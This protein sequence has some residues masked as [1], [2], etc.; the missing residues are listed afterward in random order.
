[1]S[2]LA[3]AF[4]QRHD[5]PGHWLDVQSLAAAP[6]WSPERTAALAGQCR[7]ALL[8]D[9]AQNF[10]D[11]WGPR[12]S[13]VI[14]DGLAELSPLLPEAPRAT[15]WYPV[16]LQLRVTE[17]LLDEV[18][19]GDVQGLRDALK[20]LVT[21]HR[22]A[23]FVARRMGLKRLVQK[24]GGLFGQCYD[25][26]QTEVR[27]S[28]GHAVITVAGAEL[29]THPTWQLL[30]LVGY[31]VLAELAGERDAEVYGRVGPGRVFEAHLEW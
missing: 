12:T 31:E 11:Q 4:N 20:A 14:R 19:S 23:V 1:M 18:V 7:G 6:R 29:V 25:V 28:E 16:G 21:R 17:V 15:A 3:P 30:Q 8:Q 2:L 27:V 5:L 9:W 22:A 13:L 24:V 10:E 26:G